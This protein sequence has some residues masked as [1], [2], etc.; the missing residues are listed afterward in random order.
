MPRIF[1]RHETAYWQA[2]NITSVFEVCSGALGSLVSAV[3]GLGALLYCFGTP[4]LFHP[5]LCKILARY[6]SEVGLATSTV[7]YLLCIMQEMLLLRCFA[8]AL[9]ATVVLG[10]GVASATPAAQGDAVLQASSGGVLLAGQSLPQVRVLAPATP[11]GIYA[12]Q[13]PQLEGFDVLD[14]PV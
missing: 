5:A 8:V 13:L 1:R 9:L 7:C 6:R 2:Y 4:T 3:G 11:T 10:L 12:L 14:A